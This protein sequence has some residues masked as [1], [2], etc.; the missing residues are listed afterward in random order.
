MTSP[1][2]SLIESGQREPSSEILDHLARVLGA[3]AH[4]L[5]TGKPA[6]LEAD[7]ELRVQQARLDLHQGKRDPAERKAGA[8]LEQARD[9]GLG[10]V[11]ARAL[12][13][14]ASIRKAA[15]DFDGA[16]SL[17]EEALTVW[18]DQPVHLKFE[19]IANYGVL[20]QGIGESRYAIHV[21]ESYLLE[22]DQAGLP[23][24]MARMRVHSALV[25]CYRGLGMRR[26]ANAAA[27][28]A[29]RLGPRVEDPEQI[30]CM[31]QNVAISLQDQGRHDEALEV[32][33]RAEDLYQSLDW[34]LPVAWS[35]W[36]RGIVA[37]DK[38]DFDEA[39]SSLQGAVEELERIG[40]P[41][42]D[43]AIVWTEL[44]RV[45]RLAGNVERAIEL[46]RRARPLI[47]ADE[48]AESAMNARELGLCLASSDPDAA[49]AELRRAVDLYAAADNPRERA[50]ALLHL[51]E[52]YKQRGE[53]EKAVH[54]LGEG[55]RASLEVDGSP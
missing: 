26:Q 46:L 49:V 29:L 32:L 42:S 35:R 19:T 38:G 24:P 54:A 53:M 37:G 52:L 40:G 28:T 10:R 23:D 16:R 11:H 5:A 15:N 51:G 48:V 7:L 45:E 34:A 22:L 39:R 17:L 3:D 6:G 21:L 2:L 4:E 1:Y 41:P 44:A 55:L 8:V 27:E 33:R 13:V 25:P 47:A 31:N 43:K 9:A 12:T 20:L 18:R 36:N 14:L 30:A 50:E